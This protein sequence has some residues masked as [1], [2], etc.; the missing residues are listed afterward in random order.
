MPK[1][2]IGDDYCVA[3]QTLVERRKRSFLHDQSPL[4]IA[5]QYDMNITAKNFLG[6]VQLVCAF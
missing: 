6:F 1:A 4:D 5:F 3:L 2:K